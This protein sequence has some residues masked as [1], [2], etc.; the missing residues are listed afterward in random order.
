MPEGRL[1]ARSGSVPV[2][3]EVPAQGSRPPA[4]PPAQPTPDP[5]QIPTP[6][7]IPTPSPTASPTPQ[8]TSSPTTPPTEAPTAQPTQPPVNQT[9]DPVVELTTETVRVPQQ[10]TPLPRTGGTFDSAI[11]LGIVLMALAIAIY[12]RLR[13]PS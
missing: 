5:T 10:G 7:P 13:T 4:R 1:V 6:N 2:I 12:R 8:P 11:L 3:V 9:E